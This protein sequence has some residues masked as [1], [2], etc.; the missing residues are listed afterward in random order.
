MKMVKK[1]LQKQIRSRNGG[2]FAGVSGK[3]GGADAAV[4]NKYDVNGDGKLNQA[5]LLKLVREFARSTFAVSEKTFG[6]LFR[7]M[8][9]DGD[10]SISVR[11]FY[12]FIVGVKVPKKTAT[13]RKHKNRR[14]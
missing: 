3:Q 7:E 12:D 5:E 11:E 2:M 9:S 14:R 6:A 10:G 4:F 13:R 8:N 1:Q